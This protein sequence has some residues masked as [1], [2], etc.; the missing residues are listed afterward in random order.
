MNR[1]VAISG[2]T[3]FIGSHICSLL[4]EKE[5][6]F[7]RL[8]RSSQCDAFGDDCPFDLDQPHSLDE[9]ALQ[10]IDTVIHCAA[11]VHRKSGATT[12]V[13]NKYAACNFEATKVLV[14]KSVAS[15]VG[16]F[17]FISSVAVYGL[18]SSQRVI[19]NGDAE[20][21]NTLYAQSKLDA[22]RYI[23]N[24]L[25]DKK[26]TYTILRL[27]LVYGPNAPGN[28]GLIARI[29]MKSIPLPFLNAGN[30]RSMVS[31]ENVAD[32]IYY[33]HSHRAFRNRTLI[34]WDGSEFSTEEIVSS[35]RRAMKKPRLLFFV[36]KPL[37][38]LLLRALNREKIY[39]QLYENLVFE[40]VSGADALDWQPPHPRNAAYFLEHD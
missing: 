35:I 22:E 34:F 24:F 2:A 6:S 39:Q 25:K 10:G 26:M 32:F 31:V 1:Q 17:I 38:K 8:L 11:L 7:V 33:I 19:K 18:N 36:P 13:E 4:D 15:N 30:K 28:F 21:P 5:I 12:A 23:E 40:E 29:A 20:Q 27:P 9:R 16:H 14:E 37:M 3:G